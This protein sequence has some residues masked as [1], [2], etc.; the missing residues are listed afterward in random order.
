M[1]TATGNPSTS[2]V[3]GGKTGEGAVPW[4]AAAW[5][6][7][8]GNCFG[9]CHPIVA[10]T[11]GVP[12]GLREACGRGS[13]DNTTPGGG[14]LGGIVFGHGAPTAGSAAVGGATP[15]GA[16]LGQ[17]V[18]V[19]IATAGSKHGGA[20]GGSGTPGGKAGAGGTPGDTTM[21]AA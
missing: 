20:P 7:P 9:V 12:I 5:L 19:G 2:V 8:G 10:L 14:L 11:V 6:R 18:D 16:V 3:P 21:G 13:V 17:P 15:G 4:R 1:S